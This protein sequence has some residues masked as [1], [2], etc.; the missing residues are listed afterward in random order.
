MT[1]L[2]LGVVV[3][4]LL[5]GLV[6]GLWFV[7]QQQIAGLEQQSSELDAELA[8]QGAEK[9]KIAQLQA[10]VDKVKTETDALASVF[11]QIKPWSAMLQDIRERIPPGVQIRTIQQT[12]VVPT[13][14]TA[15]P[16]PSPA[17]GTPNAEAASA[18]TSTSQLEIT[19]TARSFDEVNYLLLTLQRSS[20]VKSA[21]TQLVRAEL[22]KN[23]N[24]LE[25]NVPENR[26]QGGATVTYELPKV[27]EYKI[28]TSISDVPASELLRELDRK[29]AVGLVTRIRTLQE[30]GVI[31]K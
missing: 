11:N 22:V 26:N 16:T 15:S 6:G 13:Q 8:R 25:V 31:Q 18:P 21:E 7:L 23:A 19:G 27:V 20:F 9:Q 5:P 12:Q 1:P 4:L 10:Q 3:G 30:K 24:K 29:G 14:T 2:I 17:A 28:Q